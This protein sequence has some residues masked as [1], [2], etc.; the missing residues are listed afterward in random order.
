[1]L[2]FHILSF[3]FVLGVTAIVDKEALLWVR[4]KKETLDSA[5]L[6]TYHT[7]IWSGLGALI[8]SG[9]YL[10]WPMRLFL[11]AD[12]LFDIKLLFV[13]V[14]ITNGI[15]IGRLMKS[16]HQKPFRML[17]REEKMALLMSGAISAFSWFAAG[18]IAIAI[19]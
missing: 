3:G 15:L 9:L 14:L 8:V 5:K 18:A 10:F 16:A 12:F 11:L 17:A 2:T 6:Y 7:L 13:G 19:F 1:M 4:G